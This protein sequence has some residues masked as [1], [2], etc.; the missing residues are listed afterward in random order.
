MRQR[1]YSDWVKSDHHKDIGFGTNAE[2]CVADLQQ[3]RRS[4]PEHPHGA[5]DAQTDFPQ[6]VK[7]MFR[8][9]EGKHRARFP[10]AEAIERNHWDVAGRRHGELIRRELR[11]SLRLI[12][13]RSAGI[14]C[15]GPG[16]GNPPSGGISFGCCAAVSRKMVRGYRLMRWLNVLAF[17]ASAK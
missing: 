7:G 2:P 6:L 10:R 14:N 4:G 1:L 17:G 9:V 15:E 13:Y 16:C 8:P 5:A 3:M 12:Q 11:F